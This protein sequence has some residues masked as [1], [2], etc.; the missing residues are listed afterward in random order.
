MKLRA[1]ELNIRL[2]TAKEQISE[3]E[4]KWEENIQN[5]TRREWH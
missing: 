1:K 3:Q 4:D 5:K 2:A